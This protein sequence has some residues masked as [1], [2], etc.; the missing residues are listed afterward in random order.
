MGF[1]LAHQFYSAHLLFAPVCLVDPESPVVD[2]NIAKHLISDSD[3]IYYSA[4]LIPRWQ[5]G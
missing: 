5:Q 4:I 3:R 1:N 2:Q